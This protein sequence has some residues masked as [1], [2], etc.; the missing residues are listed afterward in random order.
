MKLSTKHIPVL[1]TVAISVLLVAQP[2]LAQSADTLK[3]LGLSI[4]FTRQNDNFFNIIAGIITFILL[5]GGLLAFFYAILGG[6][7]YLTAGGDT[8]KADNG[9]KIIVN[10][11]IGII[12]IFLS[13]SLV[14]FVVTRVATTNDDES[15][16]QEF[17]NRE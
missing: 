16:Q 10:A 15:L 12:V 7:T 6:F 17:E 2:A 5:I 14:R 11:I 3:D 1:A 4:D 9:R 13:Y 8:A